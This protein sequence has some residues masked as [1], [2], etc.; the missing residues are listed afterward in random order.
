ML[1]GY[2]EGYGA[3]PCAWLF[4]LLTLMWKY[5]GPMP[6]PSQRAA[7]A[8]YDGSILFFGGLTNGVVNGKTYQY[9]P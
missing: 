1:G 7:A 8:P 5:L 9:S 4:N 3:S 2:V 6:V